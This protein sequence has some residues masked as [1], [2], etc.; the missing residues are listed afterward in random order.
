M[1]T[2]EEL[3]EMSGNDLLKYCESLKY[4]KIDKNDFTIYAFHDIDIT[5]IEYDKIHKCFRIAYKF[6]NTSI[7]D[8]DFSI[9]IHSISSIDRYYCGLFESEEDA[10][11]TSK[12]YAKNKILEQIN[13]YKCQIKKFEDKIEKLENL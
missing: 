10:I 9:M 1:K 3:L 5:R 2:T 7:Y 13:D 12:Q 11:D 6:E 8:D 4:F